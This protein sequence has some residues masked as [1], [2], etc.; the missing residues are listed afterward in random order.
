MSSNNML[1]VC[2][3]H[4][5]TDDAKELKVTC[6]PKEQFVSASINSKVIKIIAVRNAV[7]AINY[8]FYM[9]NGDQTER[10]TVRLPS[11]GSYKDFFTANGTSV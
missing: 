7:R 4:L 3:C 11:L 1:T 10:C 9:G 5:T 6:L 2:L 8:R